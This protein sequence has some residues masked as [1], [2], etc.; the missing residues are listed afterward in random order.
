MSA[1]AVCGGYCKLASAILGGNWGPKRRGTWFKSVT[2]VAD[3]T[4]LPRILGYSLAYLY[5]CCGIATQAKRQ[6]VE[7]RKGWQMARVFHLWYWPVVVKIFW[8]WEKWG[9]QGKN[10]ALKGSICHQPVVSECLQVP[11]KYNLEIHKSSQVPRLLACF[12]TLWKWQLICL[13]FLC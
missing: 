2:Q 8:Y 7:W 13:H 3:A 6:W 10:K 1:A 5:S 11:L 9:S 12:L 4:M